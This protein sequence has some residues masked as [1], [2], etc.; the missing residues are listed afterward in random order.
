VY[1][2]F[3]LKNNVPVGESFIAEVQQYEKD[4]TSKR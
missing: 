3:C 1:D 4:V 2:M